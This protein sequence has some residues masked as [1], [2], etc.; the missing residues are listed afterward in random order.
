MDAQPIGE[1]FEPVNEELLCRSCRALRVDTDHLRC[2]RCGARACPVCAVHAERG[3]QC[4]ACAALLPE[5]GAT[6]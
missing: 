1:C 5:T 3:V 6:A 2:D 4:S